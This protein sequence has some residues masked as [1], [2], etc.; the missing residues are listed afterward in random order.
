[1]SKTKVVGESWS[2]GLAG[3]AQRDPVIQRHPEEL[4]SRASAWAPGWWRWTLAAYTLWRR[5]VVRFLRQ[6]NRIVGALGTPVVFWLL[7][8]SG[9]GRSFQAPVP[10]GHSNYLWYFFPGMLLLIVLFTAIFSTISVIE[11]RREGFLQGVL[12]SP[13]ARSAVIAAKLFGGSTLGLVQ[14]WVAYVLAVGSGVSFSFPSFLGVSA[15][16]FLLGVGLTALGFIL[17]WPLDSVQGYHALMNLLLM[18]L[19]LLSGALFPP[20]GSAWWLRWVIQA[21]PLYY[22]LELLRSVLWSHP[23]PPAQVFSYTGIVLAFSLLLAV[24][25]QV[26]M[27]KVKVRH[28]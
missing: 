12:V 9:V 18:P 7:I 15:I 1:M 4:L 3:G 16:L 25:C 20:Q 28:P 26:V 13:A 23:M 6:K 21:N 19:W 11:D 5:E 8:G 27:E 17:A 24:L 22:G 2:R 10:G 14:C